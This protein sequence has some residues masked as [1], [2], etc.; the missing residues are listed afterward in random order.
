MKYIYTQRKPRAR[1]VFLAGATLLSLWLFAVLSCVNT[2]M[3]VQTLAEGT[4]VVLDHP[5]VKITPTP[6]TSEKE[7]IKAYIREVFGDQSTNAFKI[8]ACENRSLNPLAQGTNLDMSVDTGI[9]QV[10][11]FWANPAVLKDWKTN[12]DMAHVIYLRGGWNEW[13]CESVWHALE[14]NDTI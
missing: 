12:V 2:V 10:N 11:S 1:V 5:I 7:Q 6:Q 9:F 3:P 13:A 14:R 8:L 4:G